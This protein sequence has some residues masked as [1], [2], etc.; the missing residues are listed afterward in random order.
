[1]LITP[2]S[3]WQRSAEHL[4]SQFQRCTHRADWG[5]GYGTDAMRVLLRFAFTEI[6]LHRVSLTVFGYNPRAIRSYEKAGFV[7][8]GRAR[9]RLRRDGQWWEVVYMG[10]LKDEWKER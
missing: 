2:R 10:I 4:C 7:V 9:Q 3:H 6:N 5:K 1:M 8:E